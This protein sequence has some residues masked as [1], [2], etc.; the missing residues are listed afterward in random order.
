VERRRPAF[1]LR[2]LL[3]FGGASFALLR[4]CL[5]FLCGGAMFRVLLRRL[6]FVL[7][8][9]GPEFGRPLSLL[10][11]TL[12][13]RPAPFVGGRRE[14]RGAFAVT[15]GCLLLLARPER[16]PSASWRCPTASLRRRSRSRRRF[17]VARRATNSPTPI[18]MRTATTMAIAAVVDIPSFYPSA[19]FAMLARPRQS[20]AVEA[21]DAVRELVGR[22]RL[23]EPPF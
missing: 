18:T 16:V 19:Y 20:A 2:A 6:G 14:R 5:V 23:R 21:P 13:T 7:I 11:G 4:S 10:L 8:C 1:A 3:R 15:G 17:S 22:G 12:L 9:Q